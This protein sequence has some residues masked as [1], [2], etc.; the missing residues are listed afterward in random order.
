MTENYDFF[1]EFD[2]KEGRASTDRARTGHGPV[3]IR[4]PGRADLGFP[5]CDS[6][7]VRSH[8]FENPLSMACGKNIHFEKVSEVIA[9]REMIKD[10]NN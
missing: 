7:C 4:C 6:P 9:D 5:Y 1:R 10:E 2:E 8:C 3:S